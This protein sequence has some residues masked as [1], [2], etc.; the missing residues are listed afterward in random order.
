MG[1]IKRN[2]KRRRAKNLCVALTSLGHRKQ[3]KQWSQKVK[4]QNCNDVNGGETI[5]MKKLM[6]TVRKVKIE[7]AAGHDELT[8]KQIKYVTQNKTDI[9]TV[10]ISIDL[11]PEDNNKRLGG[12]PYNTNSEKGDCGPCKNC[13]ESDC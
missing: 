12:A 2:Y 6:E 7:K 1:N 5:T 8:P 9:I 10:D 11:E 4:E 13:R 3:T